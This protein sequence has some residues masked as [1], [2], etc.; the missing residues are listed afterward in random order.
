[1]AGQKYLKLSSGR[2]AEQASA[3]ASAGAGDAGKIV[4]LDSSGRIDNSMMPVGIGADTASVVASESL[5]AGDFV[6]IWNNTGV[7]NVRKADASTTGKE[8]HGFVLDAFSSSQN[9]T[10]YFE[11]RNTAL[12]SL[13]PGTRMYLSASTA[14]QATATPPSAAGNVVQF[15]G[16]AI[17]DTSLT[18]EA[19][20]GV[21][22]A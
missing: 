4:A 12:T 17:T 13:T 15:L 9:A 7:A 19:T 1:M 21:V 22:V 3:D 20:D 18:F 8:A 2:I 16:N 10:V 11:G 5:S 14:G 6:N